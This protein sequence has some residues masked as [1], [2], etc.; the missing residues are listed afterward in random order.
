M[1][2]SWDRPRP[3]RPVATVHLRDGCHVVVVVPKP[4]D[5]ISTAPGS[6]RVLACVSVNRMRRSYDCTARSPCQFL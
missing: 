4:R 2:P 6:V 5:G 1:E 3:K